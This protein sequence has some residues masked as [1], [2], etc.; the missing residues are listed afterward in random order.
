MENKT[1]PNSNQN[2]VISHLLHSTRLLC[3][4]ILIFNNRGAIP[5]E[6]ALIFHFRAIFLKREKELF[7]S[8]SKLIQKMLFSL[9][10]GRYSTLWRKK[11]IKKVG[12]LLDT[13]EILKQF[14]HVAKYYIE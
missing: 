2:K 10:L 7:V 6:S 12:D 11:I 4:K 14:E 3:N 5:E 1:N 13:N 9:A 8:K